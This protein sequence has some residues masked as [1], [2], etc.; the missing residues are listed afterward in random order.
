MPRL[1][2]FLFSFCRTAR[3]PS[4]RVDGCSGSRGSCDCAI[5]DLL[6]RAP[7]A[8][9]AWMIACLTTRVLKLSSLFFRGK[10]VSDA[11]GP[12]KSSKL[13]ETFFSGLRIDFR[14]RD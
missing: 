3:A 5:D 12:V 13:S 11:R 6:L 14:R 9:V 10:V 2:F 8:L 1:A 4:A 7:G